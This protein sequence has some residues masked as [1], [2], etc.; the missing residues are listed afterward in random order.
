MPKDK[1]LLTLVWHGHSEAQNPTTQKSHLH[2]QMACG[3]ARSSVLALKGGPTQGASKKNATP[4]STTTAK[5]RSSIPGQSKVPWGCP[6]GI[7]DAAVSTASSSNKKCSR[8]A[9]VLCTMY[10]A[11]CTLCTTYYVLRTMYHVL[12]TMYY[13]LCTMYYILYTIYYVLCTVYYV[14]S[15]A[16]AMSYVLCTMY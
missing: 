1:Q 14:L 15:T 4:C 5:I 3:G 6:A 9:I 12:C 2:Q 13:V 8:V 10:Y 7:W 16:R 11:L